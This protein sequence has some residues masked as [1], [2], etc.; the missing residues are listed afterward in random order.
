MPDIIVRNFKNNY[1]DLLTKWNIGKILVKAQGGEKR[2]KYG[3][4][5]IK[6]WG[7]ILEKNLVKVIVKE[8]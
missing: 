5:L 6:K 2:A 7:I 3:S 4:E 8:I 1:E